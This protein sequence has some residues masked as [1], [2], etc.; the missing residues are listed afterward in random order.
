MNLTRH[1]CAGAP[2]ASIASLRRSSGRRVSDEVSLAAGRHRVRILL[3]AV[4]AVAHRVA[5]TTVEAEVGGLDV[6]LVPFTDAILEG[7][8]ARLPP[9]EGAGAR[10]GEGPARGRA[11]VHGVS[12]TTPP[13]ECFQI[14]KRLQNS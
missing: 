10:C 1:N 11:K 12:E 3:A 2:H 13:M 4:N 8:S 9:L 7:S 5:G 14:N 6:V